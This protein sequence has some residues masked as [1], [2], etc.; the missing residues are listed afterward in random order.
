MIKAR[1]K[2]PHTCYSSNSVTLLTLFIWKVILHC[3]L[4]NEQHW[5]DATPQYTQETGTHCGVVVAHSRASS[6]IFTLS[7]TSL[8][9]RT[10]SKYCLYVFKMA[11]D[12]FWI[13]CRFSVWETGSRLLASFSWVTGLFIRCFSVPGELCWLE[14]WTPWGG[15]NQQSLGPSW[16]AF[17]CSGHKRELRT[18]GR[19]EASARTVQANITGQQT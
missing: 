12:S 17:K 4:A 1:L 6:T 18:E 16:S 13:T 2:P 7:V 19:H 15:Q 14:R 5:W 8:L 10:T 11:S 3:V 9:M